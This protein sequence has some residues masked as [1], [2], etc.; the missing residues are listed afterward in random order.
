MNKD[1]IMR[2]I[3]EQLKTDNEVIKVSHELIKVLHELIKNQQNMIAFLSQNLIEAYE[4]LNE[5]DDAFLKL[6]VLD[7]ESL[8]HVLEEKEIIRDMLY[9]LKQNL[10]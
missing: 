5:R 10:E 3:E 2:P 6:D 8:N 1:E 9:T 4:A 7:E